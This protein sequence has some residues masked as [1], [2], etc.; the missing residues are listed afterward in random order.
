MKSDRDLRRPSAAVENSNIM[1]PP[2][3]LYMYWVAAEE[4]QL[5]YDNMD[6]SSDFVS[7]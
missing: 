6:K 1:A 4:L 3:P 5:S 7:K 2:N